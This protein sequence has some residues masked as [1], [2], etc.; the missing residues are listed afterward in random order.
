MSTERKA[1]RVILVDACSMEQM[2]AAHEKMLALIAERKRNPER[3]AGFSW[4]PHPE[5]QSG[6]DE[7]PSRDPC[8]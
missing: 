3:R 1:K 6:A 8:E 4:T 2:E 7:D 5:A